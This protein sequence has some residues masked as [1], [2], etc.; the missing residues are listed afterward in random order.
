MNGAENWF[1]SDPQNQYPA[2]IFLFT[3]QYYIGNIIYSNDLL[4]S[5]ANSSSKTTN[6]LEKLVYSSRR[7]QTFYYNRIKSRF[8][9]SSN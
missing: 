3:S 5:N 7:C 4:A 9:R 6:E 8:P 1:I 2:D